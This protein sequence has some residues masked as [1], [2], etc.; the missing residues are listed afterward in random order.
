MP[1]DYRVALQGFSAFERDS[2]KSFFRLASGR[3]PAYTLADS[4][5]DA[6]FVIVDA[7]R[8]EC[9]AAVR[10]AGRVGDAVFVGAHPPDDAMARLAR[11]IDPLQILRELDVMSGAQPDSDGPG[12]RPAGARFAR[13]S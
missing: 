1:A 6:A 5:V 2:L 12:S 9:V 3:T 4:L 11:P 10:D 7:D 13:W 8:P